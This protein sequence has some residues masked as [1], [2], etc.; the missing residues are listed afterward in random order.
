WPIAASAD[1]QCFAVSVGLAWLPESYAGEQSKIED[2]QSKALAA[3][4]PGLK[5]SLLNTPK[6]PVAFVGVRLFDAHTP[7]FLADQTVVVDKG[8]IVA[9]GPRGT[10]TVPAGAQVI[11]GG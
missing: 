8:A 4:A 2:A 9:V 6:S 3:Q 7:Q 1:N 11:D 10:V 5:K